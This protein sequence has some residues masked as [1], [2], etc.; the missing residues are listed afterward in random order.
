MTE[1]ERDLRARLVAAGVELVTRDGVQALGLRE[2]AR[3][4]G[5]SH[6][7]PRRY[8]PTH[9]ELLAAI[10]QHGFGKLTDALAGTD[11]VAAVSG[12]DARARIAGLARA[13]LRFA[14]ANPGMFELMFRH[15]LLEGSGAELRQTTL[16]LFRTFARLVAEVRPLPGT[17]DDT[18]SDVVTA[19]LWANLHGLAQLRAWGSLRLVTGGDDVE[20]LLRAAL[21]AH[22]GPE[23]R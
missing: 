14:A 12:A 16:P 17:S 11:A 6:G 23:R 8:F 22:L 5:V 3:Q 18:P 19:A 10:A 1:Q 2:I 7:A 21:D 4:A 13:Y 15:D 9:R 20:P